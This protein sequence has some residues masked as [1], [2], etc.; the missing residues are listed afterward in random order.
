MP[1]RNGRARIQMLCDKFDAMARNDL[2]LAEATATVEQFKAWLGANKTIW[3]WP[4]IAAALVSK[5]HWLV[6]ACDSCGTVLDLDLTFKRRHP[7]GSIR[8]ALAE[9][10][11]PRCNVRF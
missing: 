4:T 3:A 11:Y 9:V 8:V 1:E 5:H 7:D 6:I 2:A 10:R